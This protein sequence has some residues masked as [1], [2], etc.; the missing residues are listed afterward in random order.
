M[1]YE[2]FVFKKVTEL[3]AVK[4]PIGGVIL[5]DFSWLLHRSA[6]V[7][8]MLSARVNG[9]PVS[10]GDIYGVLRSLCS[11]IDRKP[12]YAI[13]LCIDS[14]SHERCEAFPAYKANRD[15]TNKKEV[16]SKESEII[17]AACSFPGIYMS[18]T[19]G[20]EADD[21][22]W[23]LSR[24]LSKV[25]PVLIHA[26]DHDLYQCLTSDVEMFEKMKKGGFETFGPSHCMSVEGVP[27]ESIPMLKALKGDK[28]DNIPGYFRLPIK[29]ATELACAY[30]TPNEFFKALTP[31]YKALSLHKPHGAKVGKWLMRIFDDRDRLKRNYFLTK[32]KTI[33]K[34]V[35]YTAA[36]PYVDILTK[37]SLRSMINK[38]H[39]Y[40]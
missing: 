35:I 24:A 8:R 3:T 18:E 9:I 14:K 5:V 1:D 26:R 25:G 7:H 12:T 32:L 31:H 36:E 6:Y 20:Y 17:A 15:D 21:V 23:T 28:S 37:Y 34:P 11:T 27:P 39:H 19:E 2:K 10:T 30:Q 4:D 13:I 16:Y 40:S 33:P 22:V 38:L 29:I